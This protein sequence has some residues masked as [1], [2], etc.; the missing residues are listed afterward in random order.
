[1]SIVLL[2]IF[3][4]ILVLL[5]Q[6]LFV[7]LG[8]V[9]VYCYGFLGN[10]PLSGIIEDLYFACDKEI[11]LSI[12]LFILAGNILAHGGIAKK[13][14]DITK[15]ITAPIP[16][17][18]AIAAVLSC[19]L[20][21]TISGSSPVTLI[22]VGSVLYPALLKAGYKKKFVLGLLSA[23]GTLGIILPPSIPMIVFAV[24]TNVSVTDLFLAGVLPGL[25]LAFLLM[26]Y[27]V[28]QGHSMPRGKWIWKNISQSF[29]KGLLALFMPAIIL[30][31]IY[32][33]FFTA[34]ESAAVGVAY[35]LLIEFC[36]YKELNIKQL[37]LIFTESSKMLGSLFLILVFSIS[38][39]KFMTFE[40]V[41]QHLVNTLQKFISN[42]TSFLIGVTLLL[43]FVGCFM[44]IISAILVLA[45][46]LTPVAI[47]FGIHP[48]H[49]GIIMIVNLEIGYLT[50]P[51]GINLFVASS[52]FKE[53]FGVVAKSVFPLVLVMLLG[54]FVITF[55]PSLSL[56]WI[57]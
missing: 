23:G 50:P 11:L 51:I 37:P 56:F 30:G 40:Q 22:A 52:I 44:D 47:H 25:F 24:T 42:K 39:N 19:A 46:L 9:C 3:I 41:P 6:P 49:F 48:I 57:H 18:L 29:K 36:F 43:L 21:A 33:G 26:A 10:L 54:L 45:P 7:I 35:A 20:F 8:S 1:V 15:S 53:P 31:G 16:A 5:K 14:I 13:L 12:P 38:L 4:F 32:S 2:C 17:G 27:S 55:T 28:A 34:T